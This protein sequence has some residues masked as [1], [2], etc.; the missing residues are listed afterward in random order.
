MSKLK[1]EFDEGG[2]VNVYAKSIVYKFC[3]VVALNISIEVTQGEKLLCYYQPPATKRQP[4]FNFTSGSILYVFNELV[5]GAC[6]R[7]KMLQA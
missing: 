4:S 1:V 3:N 5:K 2:C 7:S 6:V